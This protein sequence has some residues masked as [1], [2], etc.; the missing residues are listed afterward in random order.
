MTI[1]ANEIV[2]TLKDLY[3]AETPSTAVLDNLD[4][5]FVTGNKPAAVA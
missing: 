1:A 2:A 4:P 5:K 3:R